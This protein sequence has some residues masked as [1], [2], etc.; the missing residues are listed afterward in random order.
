MTR[1]E[2][3][4]IKPIDP[5][6]SAALTLDAEIAGLEKLKSTLS[7]DFVKAVEMLAGVGGRII[8]SG[9]GKSGHIGR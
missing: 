3:T 7:K 4:Q 6:D 5:L 9:M 2:N 1:E 8:V